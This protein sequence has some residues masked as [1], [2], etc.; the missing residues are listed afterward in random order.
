[1]SQGSDANDRKKQGFDEAFHVLGL[2]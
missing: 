2:V 1:L